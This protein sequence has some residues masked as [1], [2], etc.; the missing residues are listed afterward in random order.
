MAEPKSFW[1]VP[2]GPGGIIPLEAATTTT[3]CGG[4]RGGMSHTPYIPSRDGITVATGGTTKGH[5][6]RVGYG[7][8]WGDVTSVRQ[9]SGFG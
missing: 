1:P 9:R 8:R 6:D 5:G 2:T 4:G 7:Y 3:M